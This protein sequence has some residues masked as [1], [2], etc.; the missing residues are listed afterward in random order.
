MSE[1]V[2]ELQLLRMDVENQQRDNDE[3]YKLDKEDFVA[4][5]DELADC[6]LALA[7]E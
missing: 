2:A 7:D 3:L 1:A 6:F 4:V 5:K